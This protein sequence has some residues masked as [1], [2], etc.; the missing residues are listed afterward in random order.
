MSLQW[1]GELEKVKEKMIKIAKK[2]F[3]TANN[4]NIY[5]QIIFIY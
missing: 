5:I 1:F 2:C 4:V 3:E